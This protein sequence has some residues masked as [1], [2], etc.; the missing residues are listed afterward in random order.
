MSMYRLLIK[1]AI[2]SQ[3]PISHLCCNSCMFDIAMSYYPVT[4]GTIM[5]ESISKL[6]QPLEP[7]KGSEYILYSYSNVKRNKLLRNETVV[8]SHVIQDKQGEG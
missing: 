3:S 5:G 2:N 8:V 4:G 7:N 6:P 1:E